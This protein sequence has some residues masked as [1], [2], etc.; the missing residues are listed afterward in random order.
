M[1]GP[2]APPHLVAG[3][4]RAA[5]M[6]DLGPGDVTTDA[7]VPAAL[8][9]RGTV[10]TREPMVAS[11]IGVAL[12][13]FRLVDPELR[14][15]RAAEEGAALGAGE[16]LLEIQGRARALLKAERTALNFLAHLGGVATLTRRC[17]DV[18][19]GGGGRTVAVADTRKTTPGLRLLEKAAVA[20][21]GGRNH[22]M[23]LW[24]AVLIKDN[25]ADLAGGVGKAVAAA[26]EAS[27]ESLEVE[28]EVRSLR[29]LAEAMEAGADAVL[30]DNFQPGDLEEAIRMAG[31]KVLVEV[32]GGVRPEDLPA[33]ASLGVDR[34]SMG[35]LTHSAPAVNLT[36]RISPWES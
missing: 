32:S 31:G 7:T 17:V 2:V 22:R 11:G 12:A 36:M 25:H 4:A 14:V 19:A 23:G 26:R 20:A 9:A 28:A 30:L 24:D 1:S 10:T 3:I 34:I 33:I 27:G 21:G 8:A 35:L 15:I 16:A 6:E 18:V 13:V 29:E 5:L